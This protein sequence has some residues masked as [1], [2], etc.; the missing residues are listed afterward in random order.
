MPS[1]ISLTA[2]AA[3]LLH[4]LLGCCLHHQHRCAGENGRATATEA[5]RCCS[6]DD[7]ADDGAA[8]AAADAPS[9]TG[10]QHSQQENGPHHRGTESCEGAFCAFLVESSPHIDLRLDFLAHWTAAADLPEIVWLAPIR[11]ASQ[12]RAQLEPPPL[13]GRPQSR[14]CVWLI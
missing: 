7:A 2:A 12:R 4:T 5:E 14:L 1:I 8:H 9:G 10:L 13:I 3:I 6:H 11:C